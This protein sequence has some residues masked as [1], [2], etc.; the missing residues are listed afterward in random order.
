MF[1]SYYWTF[2][3]PQGTDH[4][5]ETFFSFVNVIFDPFK[6]VL[7]VFFLKC[8]VAYFFGVLARWHVPF[9]GYDIIE[10]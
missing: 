7:S 1:F 10:C 8:P 2:Y 4:V 6:S 5:Y 9:Q 3:K